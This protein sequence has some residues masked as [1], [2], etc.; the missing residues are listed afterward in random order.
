MASIH[1][2]SETLAT[3]LT[4]QQMAAANG[5]LRG[6]PPKL[7]WLAQG[8]QEHGTQKTCVTTF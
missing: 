4:E 6:T 8:H 7:G 5:L 1:P 2:D 3:S